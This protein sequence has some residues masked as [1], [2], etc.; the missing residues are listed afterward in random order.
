MEK[1][2]PH[3]A[4]IKMDDLNGIR[5]N[6]NMEVKCVG[7][8]ISDCHVITSFYCVSSLV[9]HKVT[10][11]LGVSNY[12]LSGSGVKSFDVE[13]LETKNG[14]TILK[15]QNRVIFDEHI[16]PTCLYPEKSTNSE[17][18]LTGWTGD[19]RECDPQLKKWHVSNSL[20]VKSYKWQMTMQQTSIIN[21]R[22]VNNVEESFKNV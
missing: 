20:V 8:L 12:D 14:V 16:L 18:L 3:I 4:L 11:Y 10:V 21:F 15:L 6:Y 22:E 13:S 5:R 17:F 2:F 19:W 1:E 7:S 9:K